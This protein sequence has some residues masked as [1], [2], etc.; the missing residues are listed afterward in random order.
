[1]VSAKE[2]DCPPKSGV[3]RVGHLVAVRIVV[4]KFGDVG[5][6][7]REGDVEQKSREVEVT[8]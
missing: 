6:G 7:I 1:M 8:N 2:P 3:A 4:D 5:E